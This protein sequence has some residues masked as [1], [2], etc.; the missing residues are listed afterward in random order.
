MIRPIIAGKI[1]RKINFKNN[2]DNYDDPLLKWPLRGC[3]FTNE[4]GEALRPLIGNFATLSWIP[5][6]L[7]IG[8]DVYDKYKNDKTEYSPD[9]KRCFKQALFQGLASIAL[10]L[11]AVKLG[12][13][14]FSTLGIFSKDKLTINTKESI[15]NIAQEFVANGKMRA[16][17]GKDVECSRDFVDIVKNNLDYKTKM[18]SATNLLKTICF[19]FEDQLR[20]FLKVNNSQKIDSFSTK[21]IQELIDLRKNLLFPSEEFKSSNWYKYFERSLDSGQTKNV[22]VKS[23]LNK[24]LDSKK[25]K[26]KFIKTAGGFLA[27]GLLIKP[28]DM[29]VDKVLIEKFVEPRIKKA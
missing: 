5:A 26:G 25:I 19:K 20:E 6:L 10:P 22:G 2:K 4:V 9:S 21:T 24:Y 1:D 23:T 13:T 27:L 29:F 8:A 15:I 3:A 12:Q 11:V 28:I 18:E 17:K 14:V 7:Y 16:Y